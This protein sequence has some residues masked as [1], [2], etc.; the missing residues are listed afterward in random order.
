MIRVLLKA[1]RRLLTEDSPVKRETD[2]SDTVSLLLDESHAALDREF[3]SIRALDRK[4]A[5]LFGAA[6]IVVSLMA[7][8]AGLAVQPGGTQDVLVTHV[9]C[10]VAL[11]A[12][13]YLGVLFCTVQAF[14]LRTYYL[15]LK[16]EREEILKDYL[17]LPPSEAR[18]QLLANYIEQ[19]GHNASVR[20]QKAKWVQRSLYVTAV[21]TGY[22]TI[23]LIFV[24]LVA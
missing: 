10:A 15:P 4:A 18:K 5:T 12:A 7:V 19:C 6:S 2:T 3:D 8:T 14:R 13:L 1:G 20:E 24:L 9:K 21:N 17:P 11:G 23:L 22:L 16:T